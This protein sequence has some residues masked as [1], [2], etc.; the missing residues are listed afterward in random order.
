[1]K[2]VLIVCGSIWSVIIVFV[3]VGRQFNTTG[4]LIVILSLL[5]FALL[6]TIYD[7]ALSLKIRSYLKKASSSGNFRL[8]LKKSQK[9]SRFPL[10]R[11][12]FYY[13][14]MLEIMC[15]INIGQFGKAGVLL[16]S[17][18]Y[19]S[20]KKASIA[21]GFYQLKVDLAFAIGNKDDYL[22]AQ[23]EMKIKFSLE[24]DPIFRID[25]LSGQFYFTLKDGFL[26]RDKQKEAVEYYR[27]WED[28]SYMDK[29]L[30]LYIK[31]LISSHMNQPINSGDELVRLAK[32]T[33]LE[34]EVNTLVGR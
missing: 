31:A 9:L 7:L 12:E 4:L 5:V 30:G 13:L 6:I 26:D 17:T 34:K 24:K 25:L 33:Y 18:S 19:Q 1:M 28:S 10:D 29:L 16:D 23:E 22:A 27:M 21:K 20:I 32:G 15:L 2:K 11:S 3:L 14:E 8:Y